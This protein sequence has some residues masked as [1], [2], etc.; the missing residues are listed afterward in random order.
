[1]NTGDKVVSISK[2]GKR[3]G[4]QGTLVKKIEGTKKWVVRWADGAEKPYAISKLKKMSKDS[5]EHANNSTAKEDV[6]MSGAD[7]STSSAIVEPGNTAV[8]DIDG[9][10]ISSNQDSGA[11]AAAIKAQKGASSVVQ[12]SIIETTTAADSNPELP[13]QHRVSDDAEG[14]TSTSLIVPND[15]ETLDATADTAN[16][17]ETLDATADTANGTKTPD[18]TADTANGTE[19]PDP[20]VDTA[21]HTETL[22]PTA[23]TGIHEYADETEEMDELSDEIGA[24]IFAFI[25]EN[26]AEPVEYDGDAMYDGFYPPETGEEVADLPFDDET[27]EEHFMYD[28]EIQDGFGDEMGTG[29]AVYGDGTEEGVADIPYIDENDEE[30]LVYDGDEFVDDVGRRDEAYIHDP[31]DTVDSDLLVSE[32][33]EKQIDEG[34]VPDESANEIDGGNNDQVKGGDVDLSSVKPHTDEVIRDQDGEKIKRPLDFFDE[35][36]A[37][38]DDVGVDGTREADTEALTDDDKVTSKKFPEDQKVGDGVDTVE[39]LPRCYI[40]C[41]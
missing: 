2:T 21:S 33:D 35:I 8:V 11:A 18:P 3:K 14:A 26:T 37:N 19:T 41:A 27:G 10:S 5:D 32:E 24:A 30:A 16:D 15:T 13:D 38:D 28:E 22:D 40:G 34:E 17:T 9:I 1:M 6:N 20:T 36:L 23:D 31:E 12:A 39:I 7:L 4:Q 25:A 29:G